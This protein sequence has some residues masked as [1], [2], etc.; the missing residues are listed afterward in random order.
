MFIIHMPKVFKVG[1]TAGCRINGEAKQVTWRDAKTLVIE[2]NDARAIIAKQNDG[3]LVCFVCGDGG[4]AQDDYDI[5]RDP[6]F[7]GGFVA[8]NKRWPK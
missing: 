3:D 1:D 5:D 2:P 8:S 6:R 4:E 7:G